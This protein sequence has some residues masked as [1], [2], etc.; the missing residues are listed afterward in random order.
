MLQSVS[1]VFIV[2]NR[3]K[4][5]TGSPDPTYMQPANKPCMSLTPCTVKTLKYSTVSVDGNNIV[6][7]GPCSHSCRYVTHN[8]RNCLSKASSPSVVCQGGN[9]KV[10]RVQPY[11]IRSGNIV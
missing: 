3:R 7:I 8:T 2:C 5:L 9:I 4:T 1:S 11:S 6:Y 10:F